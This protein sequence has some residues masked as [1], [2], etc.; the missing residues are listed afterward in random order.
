MM[1]FGGGSGAKPGYRM[2]LT[3]LGRYGIRN[4]LVS[5]GDTAHVSGEMAAADAAALL[6]ALAS[7]DDPAAFNAE[8]TGWLAGRDEARGVTQLLDA[9]AGTDPDLAG[10]RVIAIRALTTGK[11]NDALEILRDAAASGPDGR[12]HV[13]AGALASL[14]EEPPRDRETDQQWLL[15][16]LLTALRAG[17]LGENLPPGTLE[18]IRAQA[19]D[20]WRSG[21]PAAADT[22]EA[23]A[24]ALRDSD[25]TL[26]KRLRRSAHKARARG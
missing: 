15:I 8:L 4:V 21:H 10:R 7:Y 6:D 11:T 23:T 22:L 2:R 18:A 9:V 17:D 26:A 24:A 12:R 1:L 5:E 3:P 20:L 13:A 16:D 25:K 14:G 19:D